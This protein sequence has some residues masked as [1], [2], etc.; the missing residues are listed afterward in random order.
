LPPQIVHQ[1]CCPASCLK[2]GY[3]E[4]P[5]TRKP[6]TVLWPSTIPPG[7]PSRQGRLPD[8]Q[9]D[10]RP[11]KPSG[12]LGPSPATPRKAHIAVIAD[13]RRAPPP[14]TGRRMSALRCRMRGWRTSE[15]S[16]MPSAGQR[17]RGVL[18]SLWRPSNESPAG[19]CD[20]A[21][22]PTGSVPKHG[23][24]S[25]ATP[26]DPDR[27]RWHSLSSSYCRPEAIR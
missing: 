24:P 8:Q 3:V 2:A 10:W 23:G 4:H 6:G 26:R 7:P 9:P 21:C 12:A 1:P 15:G 25:R 17:V 18:T 14:E 16:A 27:P 5:G 11:G 13:S 20:T 22:V 19:V